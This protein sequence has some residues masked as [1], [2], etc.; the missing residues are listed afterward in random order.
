ML[1]S[2]A[3]WLLLLASFISLTWGPAALA[4]PPSA[5]RV[6]EKKSPAHQHYLRIQRNSRGEPV[7]L[8]TSIVRFVPAS[9]KGDLI[10]DLVGAVHI[11]DG[12][13]YNTLNKQFDQYDVVLYELVAPKGTRVPKGGRT[14]SDNPLAFVMDIATKFLALESQT[15][16]IDYTK[17]HFVHSESTEELAEVLKQRGEDAFTIGLSV[18]ADYLRQQNLQGLDS[19][20][21]EKTGPKDH[22]GDADLFSLFL[23]PNASTKLKR[24]FAEQFDSADITMQLGSTLNTI[25][26]QDR[27]KIAMKYFGKQ[28]AQ[29]K[30]RIALFYGAAHMPDF[31]ERLMK[32]YGLKKQGQHWLTAWDLRLRGEGMQDLFPVPD[33]K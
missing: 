25:L 18:V 2:R 1:L 31:E 16:A 26:I 30:K 19:E 11:A 20:S 9:G 3:T 33:R 7:A 24:N 23:D 15:K 13:Y 29:G 10:V 21:G 8:Q 22:L 28:L 17:D 32:D 14:E 4:D 27:N 6:K 5:E 12:S